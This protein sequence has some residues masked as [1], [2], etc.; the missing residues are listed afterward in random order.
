MVEKSNTDDVNLLLLIKLD[1]QT[2][3]NKL[4]KKYW[5]VLFLSAYNILR[6]QQ[7]CE[8]ITQEIFLNLWDKRKR[9]EVKKSLKSYLYA[10][11]RHE[12]FRQLRKNAVKED[13]FENLQDRL[14][15]PIEY[16]NI[17]HRELIVKINS[18]VDDLPEKCRLVY[19]LSR[20]EQLSHKQIAFQ[21]AISTKTVENHL[22]KALHQ[23][24]NA[25]AFSRY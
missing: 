16:G 15:T 17:E 7:I 13:I 12:V 22:N 2:A 3:L 20:E 6:D 1:D 11:I 23:L 8:D 18:I 25:L 10:C 14:Q 9:I 19:K 4:Y 21:L 5:R 24:R